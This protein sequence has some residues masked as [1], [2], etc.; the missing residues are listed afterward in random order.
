MYQQR[1]RALAPRPDKRIVV[2]EDDTEMRRLLAAVL[3]GEGFVVDEVSDGA[4]L[5]RLILAWEAGGRRPP[6]LLITDVQMPGGTGLGALSRLRKF[7]GEL[8]VIV[9]TAFGDAHTHARARELGALKV[10]DKPFDILELR[11]AVAAA[12]AG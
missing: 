12:L 8:A 3:A 9:I 4:E 6:D 1:Q 2:A 11:D 7:D 10:L 5:R